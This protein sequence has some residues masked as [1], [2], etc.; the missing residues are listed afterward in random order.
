MNK[1]LSLACAI[2]IASTT[3][4]AQ[5][6]HFSQ[7]Y[8]FPG[9]INPAHAG[10]M[11]EDIRGGLIYRSQWKQVNAPYSTF[12]AAV[13]MNFV[14]VP[15]FF[16]KIGAG[17]LFVNDELPD[18]IF[19]NQQFSV[20]LAMHKSLD[21]FK[22]H[23]ISFGIQPGYSI[24]S[25]V[26]N[27]L[28]SS[29]DI[30][31]STYTPP[32]GSFIS[33][34]QAITGNNNYGAFNLNAGLFYDFTVSE[35]FSIGL[36]GSLFNITSPKES[37][38]KN[39]NN[40]DPTRLGRRLLSTFSLA[41]R[42]NDQFTLLPAVMYMQQQGASDINIGTALGYHLNPNKDITVFVG[43]WYR[44][45]DAA[46]AMVG[47]QYKHVKVAFSYDATVSSFK[48][49]RNAPNVSSKSVGAYEITLTY[50]GF[51]SR[52]LPNEVTVPCRFF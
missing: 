3:V 7:F 12:G 37:I 32:S 31:R 39:I 15:A 45:S 1:F 42:M 11:K 46:I 43:G 26:S 6:F 8:N 10:R 47:M 24:K 16:D 33:K 22:R 44:L 38:V 13:D 14:K 50:V 9:A 40:Y 41:Y 49:V 20:S 35:K 28:Y 5:D 19:K 4:E 34:D 48:D 18:K 17:I 51:L 25:F 29:V 21:A 30:D 52:A 2:A 27:G 36:G 23:R